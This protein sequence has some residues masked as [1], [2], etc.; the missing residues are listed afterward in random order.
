MTA[1]TTNTVPWPLKENK[2]WL[3]EFTLEN[4]W[5]RANGLADGGATVSVTLIDPDEARKVSSTA[6]VPQM[7]ADLLYGDKAPLDLGFQ[8]LI[9]RLSDAG[10]SKAVEYFLPILADKETGG[11]STLSAD[12]AAQAL[13]NMKVGASGQTLSFF[14]E[15]AESAEFIP[16]TMLPVSSGA[17]A[18]TVANA[19]KFSSPYRLADGRMGFAKSTLFCRGAKDGVSFE[20]LRR[21]AGS[22][23]PA[24]DIP[25]KHFARRPAAGV[26]A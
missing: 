26:R 3:G 21:E 4:V 2:D 19:E 22:L 15:R 6:E 13:L 23:V 5:A 16:A 10:Q 1:Q 24:R 17:R 25:T 9:V 12:E 14:I 8:G 11:K 18:F 20:K 7:V